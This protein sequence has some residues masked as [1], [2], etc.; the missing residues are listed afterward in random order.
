MPVFKTKGTL[1]LLIV[2]LLGCCV[3]MQMVGIEASL[4]DATHIEDNSVESSISDASA[5]VA[6]RVNVNIPSVVTF[7][8][9]LHST[10]TR[11]VFLTSIFH[12]PDLSY[13]TC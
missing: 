12:P 1:F 5:L 3:V 6:D 4:W 10:P 13:G 2:G 7:G 8:N 11:Q 9:G